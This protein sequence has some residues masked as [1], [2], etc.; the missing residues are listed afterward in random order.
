MSNAKNDILALL[1][2]AKTG[3]LSVIDFETKGPFAAL[4]NVASDKNALPIFLFSN[5]ARHTKSLLANNRASLLVANLPEQGDPLTGLRATI[6]G[7]MVQVHD[8]QLRPAYLAKHPYAETYI[9][10]GD[11]N[12]WQLTPERVFV[13]AGFGRIHAYDAAEIFG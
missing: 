5:L 7:H 12:F 6:V 13:V 3:A 4:V 11:F 1:Q 8:S 10:F 9:D 2:N